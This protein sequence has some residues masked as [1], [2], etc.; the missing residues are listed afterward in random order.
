VLALIAFIAATADPVDLTGA[1]Q[2]HDGDDKSYA[3][4][5]TDDGKWSEA[6]VPGFLSDYG[7]PHYAGVLWMRKT[8]ALPSSY[9]EHAPLAVAVGTI[10]DSYELYANGKKIGQSGDVDAG[11]MGAQREYAYAVPPGVIDGKR[12]TFALRIW[13]QPD[14]AKA[15][16]GSISSLPGVYAL[17][18]RQT[19]TDSVEQSFLARSLHRFVPNLFCSVLMLLMGLA[20]LALWIIRRQLTEYLWFGL[21]GICLGWSQVGW[22]LRDDGFI[23]GFWLEHRIARLMLMSGI[24]LFAYFVAVFV[25]VKKRLPLQIFVAFFIALNALPVFVSS[26]WPFV[27]VVGRPFLLIGVVVLVLVVR[28]VFMRVPDAR[29]MLAAVAFA[30]SAATMIFVDGVGLV[31][32]PFKVHDFGAATLLVTSLSMAAVM[33]IR[34]GRVYRELDDKNVELLRLDQL[35]D[36]F[37]ANTSHE[38]RTPLNGII[39]LADSLKDGATGPLPEATKHN[40]ELI[41]LSGRR[42]ATLVNDILDFAKLKHSGIALRSKP[43]DLHSVVDVVLT[44]S[45]PLA[46]DKGLAL[47][48][49]VPAELAA[50]EADEDRLQ[51]IMHNLVG[52]AIKFTPKGSVEVTA[53]VD[54]ARVVVDVIDSGIGIPA[55]K[56]ARIFESFEQGD[57]STE[58]TYGGTG[59]G[60]AVTKK[61]VELHGGSI[62]VDSTPG[63]G[64]R[65]SFT[66][67]TAQAPAIASTAPTASVALAAHAVVEHTPTGPRSRTQEIQAVSTP[68]AGRHSILVVDDEPVNLQVLENQ[69]HIE[70]FT[71][72]KA[73]NGEEALFLLEKGLQADAVVLDVM[74]PKLSGY[75]V[76]RRI[77]AMK[78]ARVPIVLLTAKGREEDVVEG[79]ATGANDYLVKP[80]NKGELV[81]RLRTHLTLAKFDEAARRFVPFTFLELLGKQSLVDVA[82]GEGVQREMSVLFADI[83]SFTTMAEELGPRRIFTTINRYLAHMQ[84]AVHAHRGFINQVYGDG[85]MALFT[86]AAKDA[87]DASIAMQH[88]LAKFNEEQRAQ[89]G[90]EFRIGIG[91]NTGPLML[92]TFG[93]L[94]RMECGVV[95]D[96]VNTAARVEGL[97]KMYGAN[98]LVGE[99]TFSRLDEKARV[100]LREVDRVIV[101][102]K[103]EPTS[104]YEVVAADRDDVAEKKRATAAD[105]AAGLASY[106]AARF[107]DAVTSFAKCVEACA[108]DAA[109]SIYLERCKGYAKNGAP[110]GFDGIARLETK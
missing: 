60:L 53:R 94:Q 23:D 65:F 76:T 26:T 110:V 2:V 42:L 83:R 91:V 35:K 34:F 30:C 39:G 93:D 24:V 71:V 56:I 59:L 54:G 48:N 77:R 95:S 36:E 64:S 73:S 45:T 96:T 43:V 25:D 5:S 13:A 89:Q 79:L 11:I 72:V 86:G 109:S 4:A 21:F 106:R 85:I 80:F 22:A 33:M 97:T 40:L 108:S 51:Q 1:W 16:A 92:G 46:R 8:I 100:G 81:A 15:Y 29:P 62:A 63:K 102:G 74:M 58:R 55:D 69:L 88:A 105:F 12:V 10:S 41:A 28:A 57:G 50:V 98:A 87:V 9:D 31:S 52:N 68:V 38:L 27:V 19:L 14:N 75:E 70:G 90:P 84:P 44:L 82:L 6:H 61:L 107:D 103:H 47:V 104:I 66:L 67:A 7:K 78:S 99:T 101:K 32:L 17:G 3:L 18:D 37:M 20:S 49:A